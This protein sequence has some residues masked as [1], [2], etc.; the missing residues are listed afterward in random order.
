MKVILIASVL[1][2]SERKKLQFLQEPIFWN[3]QRVIF[4][5]DSFIYILRVL[6]FIPN[7]IPGKKHS[8]FFT[9]MFRPN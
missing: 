5:S 7:P 3:K 4:V 6:Y 1:S 8:S 2:W 9:T